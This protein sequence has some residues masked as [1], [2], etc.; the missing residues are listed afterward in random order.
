MGRERVWSL[1]G[2]W[3]ERFRYGMYE[4]DDYCRRVR[5]AGLKLAV[6]TGV[7]IRHLGS[8]TTK[9]DSVPVT[10]DEMLENN[11]VAY[12]EKWQSDDKTPVEEE[13]VVSWK[14]VPTDSVRVVSAQAVS[15]GDGVERKEVIRNT[16]QRSMEK[17]K[18][19]GRVIADRVRKR[20]TPPEVLIQSDM[21]GHRVDVAEEDL[22]DFPVVTFPEPG[23]SEDRVCITMVTCNRLGYT[24]RSLETLAE[25]LAGFPYELFIVDNASTDATPSYLRNLAH[26]N[27]GGRVK[28]ILLPKRT[29]SISEAVNLGWFLGQSLGCRWFVKLD[30]D[31]VVYEGWL[32]QMISL[33]EEGGYGF[34]AINPA[35]LDIEEV[36]D[37]PPYAKPPMVFDVPMLWGGCCLVSYD[38]FSRAGYWNETLSRNEDLEY[39]ARASKHGIASAFVGRGAK[40]NHL[41]KLATERE[42]AARQGKIR[43]GELGILKDLHNGGM[44]RVGTVW[45]GRDV[46]MP[47]GSSPIINVGDSMEGEVR[48]ALGRPRDAFSGAKTL[49]EDLVNYTKHAEI[50]AWARGISEKRSM[51]EEDVKRVILDVL[52]VIADLPFDQVSRLL[53]QRTAEGAESDCC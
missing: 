42:A 41:G 35:N 2:P 26:A 43:Q 9:S 45:E 50:E 5:E 47:Y 25:T 52:E 37:D 18:Q 27:E 7:F 51:P 39:S 17:Q 21:V 3:D 15:G 11:R 48:H 6:N 23:A 30:N 1:V 53:S 34:V 29:F 8:R 14:H 44:E 36:D 33:S 46:P 32:S 28:V 20:R 38:A 40:V 13:K 24:V 12:E 19:V 10:F 4:D 22:A 16:L 31:I 49:F